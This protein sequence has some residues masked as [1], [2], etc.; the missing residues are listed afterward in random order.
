M[1][2]IYELLREVETGNKPRAI[3]FESAKFISGKFKAEIVR[4]IDA[5]HDKANGTNSLATAQM[6]YCTSFGATQIMG[7]NLWGACGYGGTM[8]DYLGD[9][10]T[11]ER[12]TLR[13]LE[14]ANLLQYSPLALSRNKD[15]RLK[16]AKAYNGSI[17][18]AYRL[19]K[20]LQDA[21]FKVIES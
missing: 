3:R 11:Q 17:D 12:M 9:E 13:F 7:F 8:F 21:G 19:E 16:F 14:T 5:I 20:A 4:A 6:M 10:A 1:K 15:S 18:Y 2:N